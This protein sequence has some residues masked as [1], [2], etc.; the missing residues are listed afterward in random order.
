MINQ[1]SNRGRIFKT[2]F[3]F[4]YVLINKLQ[5]PAEKTELNRVYNKY[6]RKRWKITSSS[7]ADLRTNDENVWFGGERERGEAVDWKWR[8]LQIA[9]FSL[10]WRR[11]EEEEANEAAWASILMGLKSL[12]NSNRLNW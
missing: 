2:E 6:I 9:N 7:M 12:Y 10:R 8:S 1:I 4:F 5:S 3:W 11:L